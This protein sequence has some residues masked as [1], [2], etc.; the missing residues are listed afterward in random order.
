MKHAHERAHEV[1]LAVAGGD[2]DVAR[3]STAEWMQ[4]HIE[5]SLSEVETDG[6]HQLL[7]DP[8]LVVNREGAVERLDGW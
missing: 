6:L 3:G 8:S 1:C 5:P 7:A 2:P 4:A